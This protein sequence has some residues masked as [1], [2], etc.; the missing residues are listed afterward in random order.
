MAPHRYLI[1]GLGVHSQLPL[2]GEDARDCPRDVSVRWVRSVRGREPRLG[3]DDA[4]APGSVENVVTLVWPQCEM[5]V[6]AGRSIVLRTADDGEVTHLRHLVSGIGLGLALHQRGI[7]T[8]HASAVAIDGKAVIFVGAKGAGKSTLVGA[9]AARGHALLTDDVA[10]VDIADDAPPRVRVGAPNLNLWPDSAT[11]VAHD[12]DGVSPITSLSPKLAGRVTTPQPT[13][14]MPLAAVFVL[15][16]GDSSRIEPLAPIEGFTELVGHSHAFRWIKHVAN[17]ERHFSQCR[18]VLA[19][20]AI[21]RL[22]RGDSLDAVFALAAMVED[23]VA[24]ARVADAAIHAPHAPPL[25]LPDR[26]YACAG[27]R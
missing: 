24:G 17:L 27:V 21:A 2:W 23:H 7:F 13:A 15:S 19:H 26:R 11:V 14:P 8:L 6:R 3:G 18:N 16:N 12:L 25:P 10:A 4:V 22:R 9:L 5:T 1:Y 20:A